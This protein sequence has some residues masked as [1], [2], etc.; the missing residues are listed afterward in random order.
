VG[1]LDNEL[2]SEIVSISAAGVLVV[3]ASGPDVEIVYA[4]PAYESA[5]GFEADELVGTSWLSYLAA[6][7]GSRELVELKQSV[8]SGETTSFNLPFLRKDGN[9]WLGRLRLTPLRCAKDE[10]RLVVVEH[11]TDGRPAA[12]DAELLK[13]ALGLARKRIAS[14][15]RTDP[16][17]C[18]MS[19]TQ[20]SLMLRREI[21]V[22]R[23][24]DRPLHLMLFTIPELDVYRG[25]Y[26]NN[27]ADS[28]LRMIGAQI[29]GTFRRASDLSARIDESTLA[30]A[31]SGYEMD[32]AEQRVA[33][34]EKKARSLGLHNPRGR[35]GRYVVV[36]GIVVAAD[37]AADDVDALLA[38]GYAALEKRADEPLTAAGTA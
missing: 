35:C 4:N 12:E 33:L 3:D 38:R 2:F 32:D 11:R 7:D 29:A 25:T 34:V 5:S 31:V 21:A 8:S 6:D 36:Q 10:R 15:D 14:L 22:A 23:R 37:P 24:E 1:F 18:L 28:C 26:G 27:A 19:K 20:F 9:I 16:V 17:T 13:R 30:V